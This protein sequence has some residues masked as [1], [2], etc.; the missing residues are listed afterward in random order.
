M[1][2]QKTWMADLKA[3]L[4]KYPKADEA[5]DALLQL[6]SANEFNAEEDEARKYYEQLARDFPA[7]DAGKKA[8][9]ALRRLDL[10]GKPLDLKGPGLQ[11]PG[12]RRRAVSGQDPARHLL[13]ELG[14]PRPPRPARAGQGLPEVPAARTS[15]SSA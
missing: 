1:A 3:F 5:P 14:R 13:G 9:G 7:T 2:N 8:A 12:G 6:A 4:D 11:G 15:R 10:V